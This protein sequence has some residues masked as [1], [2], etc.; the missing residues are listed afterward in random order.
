MFYVIEE[1][2][3]SSKSPRRYFTNKREMYLSFALCQARKFDTHREA[4][5]ALQ[6]FKQT[7]EAQYLQFRILTTT[8]SCRENVMR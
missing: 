8:T 5:D 2:P 7:R 4:L 6:Q 3:M 1:I